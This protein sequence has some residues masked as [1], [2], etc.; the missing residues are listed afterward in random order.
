MG[1]Y[2]VATLKIYGTCRKIGLHDPETCFYLPSP[3]A[4]LKDI[5]YCIIK[6]IGT[7]GIKAIIQGFFS[8]LRLIK[9]VLDLCP[10]P[11]L[12]DSFLCDESC[13]IVR[14]LSLLCMVPGLKHGHG[15]FHLFLP[16][17]LLIGGILR[18]IGYDKALFQLLRAVR[19]FF[20]KELIGI[21]IGKMVKIHE[22]MVGEPAESLAVKGKFPI[23]RAQLLDRLRDDKRPVPGVVE[24]TVVF[25]SESCIRAEYK[26][27]APEVL[28]H[29]LFQRFQGS[30]FVL[31]AGEQGKGKGNAV[32]V[33]KQT[34]LYD[35]VGPVFFALAVFLVPIFL[36]YL[37]IVVGA[38]VVKD[39]VVALYDT[40]AVFINR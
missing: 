35:R 32:T 4:H 2:P 12:C 29:F 21:V 7:Y 24:D 36:F 14:I 16:D 17:F 22:F 1:L 38:V 34:H 13:G 20:V 31:A 33:C 5:I 27:P 8:Y 9:V 25:R 15:P 6:Q 30:L 37:E 19:L 39:M 10:L 18:G 23:F 28:D 40:K 11:I 26:T 3:F